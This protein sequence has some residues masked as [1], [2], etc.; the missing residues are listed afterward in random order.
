MRLVDLRNDDGR[1]VSINPQHVSHVE[2]CEPGIPGSRLVMISGVGIR[3]Q[4]LRK[5]VVDLLRRD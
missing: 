5:Q 3:V 4:E 2:S 1:V